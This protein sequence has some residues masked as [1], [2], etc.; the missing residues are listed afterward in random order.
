M[1]KIFKSA[2]YFFLNLLFKELNKNDSNYPVSELLKYA[3]KQKIAGYNRNVPW[4]VHFTSQVKCPE[5]ILRGTKYPGYAK[6]CYIDG[7][8]GIIFEENVITGPK[9]SIISQNHDVLNFNT[10]LTGKPVIIRKNSWLSTGCIIL[11]EVELGEHTIVAAGAVVT[12]SF[13]DGNQIIAGNPA[14]VIKKIEPYRE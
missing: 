7:R 6:G 12:K 2:I 9:V 10:Y 5:K 4:P 8:N 14:Q 1:K 11:P 13:P 3:Y